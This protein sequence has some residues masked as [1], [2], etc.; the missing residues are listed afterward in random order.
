MEEIAQIFAEGF[1]STGIR[2]EIAVDE[3]PSC[4]PREDTVQIVV[5]PHEFYPL[6]LFKKCL[7]GKEHVMRAVYHL[8]VEQPGSRWFEIAYDVTRS[9]RGA[10]DIS[11]IGVEEFRRR[12]IRAIHAP[13]CY[14]SCLEVGTAGCRETR[15]VDILFMGCDSPRRLKFF[16]DN[17]EWFSRYECR[18]ILSN[19]LKP[20]FSCT[21]GFYAGADRNRLMRESK[22]ILNIHHGE[23]RYFE[24]PRAMP[25]IANRCLTVSEPSD[26][27]QPLL[28]G[29]HL[30]L[31]DREKIPSVCEEYLNAGEERS[32]MT[33]EAYRVLVGELS[34]PK[35]CGLILR[36]LESVEMDHGKVS[37]PVTE[38]V[39]K[40]LIR[41][42]YR[43]TRAIAGFIK[44][45]LRKRY[46]KLKEWVLYKRPMEALRD[47]LL[48]IVGYSPRRVSPVSPSWGALE[49]HPMDK[50]RWEQV[51]NSSYARCTDPDVTVVIT[52]YNY[53][54]YVTECLRSVWNS[55]TTDIPGGVEIVVIDD[56]STDHSAA[57]VERVLSQCSFP[58]SLVKKKKNSGLS[59]SRNM[60]IRMAR[61]PYVFIL[62]ADNTLFPRCLGLLFKTI[63]NSAYAAVYG[64]IG[65]FDDSTGEGAGLVSYWEWNVSQL[66]RGPYIDAM[67]MF[68][69]RILVD[70]GGYITEIARGWEDYHLWLRVAQGGYS[71]KLVPQIVAS[72]RIHES[73]MLNVTNKFI[74]Q[75]HDHFRRKFYTLA[76]RYPDLEVL[77]TRPRFQ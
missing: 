67:A 23:R 12:G 37:I 6:F 59:D 57:V 17:A 73:N 41:F 26:F 66:L 68:D 44:R 70:L 77:F 20:Q 14:A 21:P 45:S 76:R 30:L 8:N 64:I 40:L 24:W 33:D 27:V 53:A 51:S 62:D 2:A 28:H 36:E 58:M 19:V 25:A 32:R 5:A 1:N 43:N 11:Q 52:L 47:R 46:G 65:K 3:I 16:S 15:P 71:C 18:I 22:I 75:F 72:Y 42:P 9:A 69:K 29:K 61:S 34:G 10:L 60:G 74:P 48:P 55:D 38:Q 35:I 49:A 13:L 56:A 39:R 31:A 63:R 50:Q 4:L 7:S 54:K